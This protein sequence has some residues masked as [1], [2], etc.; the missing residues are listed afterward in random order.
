[1][2]NKTYY[3]LAV[4]YEDGWCLEFGSYDREDVMDERKEYFNYTKRTRVLKTAD[5]QAAIDK[6]F[7]KL[8]ESQA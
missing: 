7:A 4:K 5:N 1:M 8:V 3:S 6:A 2:A